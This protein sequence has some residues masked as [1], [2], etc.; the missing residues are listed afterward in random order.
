[1]KAA[2]PTM[3]KID[4]AEGITAPKLPKRRVTTPGPTTSS[5]VDA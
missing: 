1:M 4:P 3:L 5:T 2:V